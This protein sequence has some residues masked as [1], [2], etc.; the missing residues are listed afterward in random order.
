MTVNYKK[1]SGVYPQ[2]Q[3]V[4]MTQKDD[5]G[6]HSW[7]IKQKGKTVLSVIIKTEKI[8]EELIQSK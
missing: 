1:G 5:F 2:E 4:V 3:E 8:E 6:R 7:C